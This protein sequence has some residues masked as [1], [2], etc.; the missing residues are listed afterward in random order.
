M[1]NNELPALMDEA[2]VAANAATDDFI[3]SRI[4]TIRGV[5]VI[6]DRDLGRKYCAVAKMDAMFIPS[7]IQRA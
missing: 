7:I 1:T 4:F 2:P 5:Q 3:K 6:L